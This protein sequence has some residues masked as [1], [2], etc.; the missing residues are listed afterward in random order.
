[1][2][3][4]AQLFDIARW[5]HVQVDS[6]DRDA[7]PRFVPPPPE[8][9]GGA[10]TKDA[11]EKLRLAEAKYES[12]LAT[13]E[14]ETK[15]R[16]EAERA[17]TEHATELQHLKEEGQKVATFLQFNEE[18]TRRRLIDQALIAAG[19]SVGANGANTEEVR[20]EVRLSTMPTPSGEG[21]AD[22]VL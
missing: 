20:Q 8:P 15:K 1:L 4:L 19:W 10:K 7:A 22:Y 13:L 14:A 3:C 18:T 12:V 6:G 2:E 21:F 11:L 16:L 17:A 9:E 5:F